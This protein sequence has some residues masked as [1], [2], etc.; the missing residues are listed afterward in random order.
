MSLR[1]SIVTLAASV[2]L[3]ACTPKL[4][5]AKWN[6]S[7]G[8]SLKAD[9]MRLESILHQDGY[10]KQ[11]GSMGCARAPEGVKVCAGQYTRAY[12]AHVSVTV[13]YFAPDEWFE[14]IFAEQSDRFA[15]GFSRIGEEQVAGFSSL[16][17]REFGPR[18]KQV[19]PPEASN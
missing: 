13:R 12:P 16:L 6:I 11:A 14:V 5:I 8:Q 4:S 19:Y 10:V 1:I 2:V 17:L 3:M 7:L 15:G 18:L 9:A